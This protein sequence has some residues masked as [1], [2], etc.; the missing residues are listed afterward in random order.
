MN[1][2]AVSKSILQGLEIKDRHGLVDKDAEELANKLN[3]GESGV[4]TRTSP[5]GGKIVFKDG[6]K[7]EVFRPHDAKKTN[8]TKIYASK[9]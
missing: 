9:R 4:Y 2:S 5:H 6:T 3:K 8:S 1:V 7:F